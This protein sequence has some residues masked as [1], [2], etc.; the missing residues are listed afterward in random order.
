MFVSSRKAM[1][2]LAAVGASASATFGV[3]D[4]LQTATLQRVDQVNAITANTFL[5]RGANGIVVKESQLRNLNLPAGRYTLQTVKDNGVTP[6]NVYNCLVA[7]DGTMSL[8]G[9]QVYGAIFRYKTM[10]IVPGLQVALPGNAKDARELQQTY[11]KTY[12]QFG[13]PANFQ[14][15]VLDVRAVFDNS[16]NAQQAAKTIIDVVVRRSFELKDENGNNIGTLTRKGPNNTTVPTYE[17]SPNGDS[18]GAFLAGTRYV[19]VKHNGQFDEVLVRDDK[20]AYQATPRWMNAAS[21]GNGE[22]Y[23]GVKPLSF[24]Y[25]GYTGPEGQQPS[26][27]INRWVD[28]IRTLIN[29]SYGQRR[30]ALNTAPRFAARPIV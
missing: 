13:K 6:I 26:L 23:L 12:S 4:T 21:L 16:P 5:F 7:G 30:M 25:I 10:T 3:S 28:Q 24:N 11:I 20:C 19:F 15:E 8:K 9:A 17:F 2:T 14:N 27:Q 22:Q 29:P 1:L 18:A